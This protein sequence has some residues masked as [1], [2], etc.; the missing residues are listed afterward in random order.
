MSLRT[1]NEDAE[2]ALD[3]MDLAWDIIPDVI[4][5]FVVLIFFNFSLAANN[6]QRF[7]SYRNAYGAFRYLSNK[8]G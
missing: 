4:G 2:G 1:R 3:L 8:S 5:R 7:T 6:A